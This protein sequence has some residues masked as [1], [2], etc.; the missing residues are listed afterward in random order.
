MPLS[1]HQLRNEARHLIHQSTRVVEL[2]RLTARKAKQHR[3]RLSLIFDD[4][5]VMMRLISCW[6]R[7]EYTDIPW[8][9]LLAIVGA[10]IYFVNPMDL[11]PDF[12][13]GLGLMDDATIIA[14][15]IAATRNDLDRFR[16]WYEERTSVVKTNG[17]AS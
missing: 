9:S 6:A 7:R 2:A 10:L 11:V 16:V 14:M 12:V 15:V 8:N 13:H 17:C 3:A 1:L 5:R 4:L